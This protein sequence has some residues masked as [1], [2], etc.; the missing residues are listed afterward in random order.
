[1]RTAEDV[2]ERRPDLWPVLAR[3]R[4]EVRTVVPNASVILY[5]SR[6]R[7]DAGGQSD[8]DFLVLVEGPV[9][10]ALVTE[11]RDRLYDLELETG[12]VLSAIVRSRAE[13]RSPRY[14]VLPLKQIVEHEGI[15]L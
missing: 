1:M 11:V 2:Q 5:G 4:D 8:W 6:A 13:W 10:Q 14:S 12:M 3:V 15:I 7:G 9:D